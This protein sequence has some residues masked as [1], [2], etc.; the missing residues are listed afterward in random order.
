MTY[1][2]FIK[3]DSLITINRSH[4]IDESIQKNLLYTIDLICNHIWARYAVKA[5]LF[6]LKQASTHSHAS[7][8]YLSGGIGFRPQSVKE[9]GIICQYCRL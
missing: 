5:Q 8:K 6:H 3:L 9:I 1:T 4:Q 2:I 7:L